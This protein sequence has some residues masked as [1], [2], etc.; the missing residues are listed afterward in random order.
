[1]LVKQQQD[2][3]V[4]DHIS[5]VALCLTK[6]HLMNESQQSWHWKGPSSTRL[7]HSLDAN[8]KC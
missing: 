1:M 4:E 6:A 7:P 2:T 5:A 3:L 8:N